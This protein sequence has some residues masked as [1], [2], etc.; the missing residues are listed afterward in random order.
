MLGGSTIDEARG[1]VDGAEFPARVG[2]AEGAVEVRERGPVRVAHRRR[3]LERE[4]DGAVGRREGR[5]AHGGHRDVG[6]P[7]AVE[8]EQRGACDAR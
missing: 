8:Q 2:D 5:Q 1:D 4:G 3:L 6:G 7:R